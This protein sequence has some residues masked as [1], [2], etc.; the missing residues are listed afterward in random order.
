VR[1]QGGIGQCSLSVVES[2]V[3]LRRPV[4]LALRVL[5]PQGLIQGPHEVS[6]VGNE[7]V[8]KVHHA[9]ELLQGLHGVGT[10]KAGDGVHSGGKQ[11]GPL[12]GDAVPQEINGRQ[13]EVALR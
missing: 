5:A 12:W 6:R 7:P 8:V 2:F 13:A 4:H 1:Q 11:N 3:H 10:W 9:Q